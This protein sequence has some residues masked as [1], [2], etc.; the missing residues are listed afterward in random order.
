MAVTADKPAP[1]APV[2]TILEIVERYRNRGLVFPV[3]AEVLARAGVP[4]SLVSRTL[5]ALVTLD[6]FNNEGN[7]TETIEGIRLAPE[8]EY[9]KRLQDWLKSTYSDVFQFVDPVTDDESRIRDAFRSYQPQGQQ[10]R[11]VALFQGLCAAAGLASEKKT[12]APRTPATPSRQRNIVMQARGGVHHLT[13]AGLRV[14]V[15]PALSDLPPALAG[16]LQSLPSTSEGWTKD[17]R[18]KFLNAFGTVLDLCFPVVEENAITENGGQP[19]TAAR[20]N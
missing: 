10:S 8:A 5:Q 17:R 13:A 9:Q 6:L 18:G 11:M 15:P 4:E 1:Y 12:R 16:L 3:T 19:L 7:P 2:K 14:G 20:Q